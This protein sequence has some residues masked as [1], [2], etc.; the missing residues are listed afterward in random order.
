M[1]VAAEIMH[2]EDG[3]RATTAVG[4]CGSSPPVKSGADRSAPR[5]TSHLIYDI[6]PGDQHIVTHPDI[7]H[8]SRSQRAADR[9]TH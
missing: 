8:F 1:P 2:K 7:P 5:C 6:V 9:A 4:C 3:W